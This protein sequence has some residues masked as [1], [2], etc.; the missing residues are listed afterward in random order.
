[1]WNSGQVSEYTT[2]LW[3]A[4]LVT[5]LDEGRKDG[6]DT[7]HKIR[8]I[9]LCECLVKFEEG[10]GI[11]EDWDGVKKYMEKNANL[12]VGTP[13]GNVIILRVLQ[14][15]VEEIEKENEEAWNHQKWDEL[16]ALIGIDLTNAYGEYFRSEAVEEISEELPR[17]N[18]R[19]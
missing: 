5:P 14:S 15:W 13:D 7:G 6:T 19:T 18:C 11:V 2:K 10:V 12:G 9:T 4:G 17:Q 3:T 16:K 8:P 1:M